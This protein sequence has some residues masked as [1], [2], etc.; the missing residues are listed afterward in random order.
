MAYYSIY[1]PGEPVAK[2]RP[3]V[4]KQNH[5]YTP[6]KTLAHESKIRE[7]WRENYLDPPSKNLVS[8]SIRFYLTRPKKIPKDFPEY[9]GKRPD[10]D[11]LIKTVLDALNGLAYEDD[12]QVIKIKARKEWSPTPEG[13]GYTVIEVREV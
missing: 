5:I 13:V 8:L 12:K 10:I 9:P 3:R 7:E 6:K 1:V 11:N 2:A 4:G